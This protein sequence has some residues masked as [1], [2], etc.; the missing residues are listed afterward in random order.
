MSP[1]VVVMTAVYCLFGSSAIA[2]GLGHCLPDVPGT[3][4]G[5]AVRGATVATGVG[6]LAAGAGP[7]ASTTRVVAST[8]RRSGYKF[9]LPVDVRRA[10]AQ[11]V[12]CARPGQQWLVASRLA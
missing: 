5:A 11:S 4:A 3:A 9:V 6:R 8:S 12:A 10:P 2:G 7:Q 1:I